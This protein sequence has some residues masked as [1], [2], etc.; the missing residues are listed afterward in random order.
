MLEKI[1]QINC[2]YCDKC[3]M[4]N[5]HAIVPLPYEDPSFNH[6]KTSTFDYKTNITLSLWWTFSR[7]AWFIYHIAWKLRI[8]IRSVQAIY[9]EATAIY[10]YSIHNVSPVLNLQIVNASSSCLLASCLCLS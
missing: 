4:N 1:T 7:D 3:N 9:S 6:I 2:L 8:R 5:T 10:R